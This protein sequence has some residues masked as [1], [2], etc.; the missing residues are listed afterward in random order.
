MRFFTVVVAVSGII[1][2][3]ALAKLRMNGSESMPI[4]IYAVGPAVTINRGD[5]VSAC[6][7]AQAQA[8]GLVR[9]YLVRASNYAFGRYCKSGAQPLLK[10]V[11]ALGGDE[12]EI[13]ADSFSVNRKLLDRRR[14][15][16]YDRHHRRLAAFQPGRYRLKPDDVWLYSPAAYG[17]DSRYF[18]PA[19]LR[20]IMGTAKPLLTFGSLEHER[21]RDRN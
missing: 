9:G 4:G 11:A 10:Y 15:D 17:W 14:L 20:D 6:P 19:K 5:I 3:L 1:C 12:I 21:R 7:S 16:R 2:T 13:T 18:G 8:L